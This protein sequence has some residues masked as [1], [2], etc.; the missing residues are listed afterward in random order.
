MPRA[1]ENPVPHTC[2]LPQVVSPVEVRGHAGVEPP[3]GAVVGAAVP[4]WIS[5]VVPVRGGERPVVVIVRLA[6]A[7]SVPRGAG[8]APHRQPVEQTLTRHLEVLVL[9]VLLHP[10]EVLQLHPQHRVPVPRQQV[11]HVVPEP[12]LAPVQ[13]PEARPVLGPGAV[14]AHAAV[15]SPLQ[16]GPAAT[17][18]LHVTGD[19]E[20]SAADLGGHQVHAAPCCPSSEQVVRAVSPH[21]GGCA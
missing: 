6:E 12:E 7:E 17:G 11:D 3:S 1:P 13:L 16:Q 14:E 21:R 18:L 4:G 9:C 2:V 10:V 5:V 15:L 20:A 8:V 19:R